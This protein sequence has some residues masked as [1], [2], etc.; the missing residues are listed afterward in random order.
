MTVATINAT[1][2]EVEDQLRSGK[3]VEAV[4]RELQEPRNNV[5]AVWRAMEKRG[6]VPTPQTRPFAST[7]PAAPVAGGRALASV[8]A[9][10]TTATGSAPL[11]VDALANAAARSSSK[12]TQALGKKL[13]DL[14][15]VIRQR[16]NDER[17]AAE[18]AEKARR[19]REAAAA[20]VVRLK[21]ALEEAKKKAKPAPKTGAAGRAVAEK[22]AGTAP[23]AKGC[24]RE[25]T[26]LPGPRGSHEKKCE[27]GDAA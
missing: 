24:G 19:E 15:R 2:A 3:S 6:E 4:A 18:A 1:V 11:S 7:T 20:E 26:T 13:A 21:A 5:I 8:A 25:L 22:Y 17:V 23:C 14:A 9:Q 16:L 27:G 12:R 10:E